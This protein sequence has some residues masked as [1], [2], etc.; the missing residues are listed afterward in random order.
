MCSSHAVSRMCAMAPL[1]LERLLA[2]VYGL[3]QS[4]APIRQ[5]ER[6]LGLVE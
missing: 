5:S 4:H 2:P 1:L 3:Y 6:G